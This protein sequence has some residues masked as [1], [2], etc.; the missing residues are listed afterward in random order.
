[1]FRG[2][3]LRAA[4]YKP[5]CR[6]EQTTKET[7]EK[8]RLAQPWLSSAKALPVPIEPAT[9]AEPALIESALAGAIVNAWAKLEEVMRREYERLVEDAAPR[10]ASQLVDAL[11]RIEVFSGP[12]SGVADG[13]G[14]HRFD[15][16][17]GGSAPT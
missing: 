1:M 2:S 13:H 16:A 17:R 7:P 9:A 3:S 8:S 4:K 10:Q 6:L 12:A 11:R 14:P 15:R 5:L